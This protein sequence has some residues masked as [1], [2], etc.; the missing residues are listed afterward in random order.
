MAE[1]NQRQ[2]TGSHQAWRPTTLI[3]LSATLSLAREK[4][5]LI[6]QQQPKTK[7]TGK[8]K[9]ASQTRTSHT[10]YTHF[11][12]NQAS[13]SDHRHLTNTSE[14]RVLPAARL[15]EALQGQARALPLAPADPPLR[16]ERTSEEATLGDVTRQNK[17]KARRSKKDTG[18]S[19]EVVDE[20]A[21]LTLTTEEEAL[22]QQLRGTWAARSEVWRKASSPAWQRTQERMLPLLVLPVWELFEEFQT[23]RDKGNWGESTAAQYWAALRAA[24][25]PLRIV[26]PVEFKVQ[27][28]VLGWEAKEAD[29]RRQT[30]AA[31]PEQISRAA[32][33]LEPPLQIALE[34]AFYLGQRMGDTI[35][36][37]CRISSIFDT[38]TSTTFI[39]CCFIRGK[40]T[41]RR[42]PYT[43]H[44]PESHP[45]GQRLLALQEQRRKNAST[46]LFVEPPMRGNAL[47]TIRGALQAVDETLGLLSV[48]RGGLQKM[49]ID[50]ASIETLI[51][52]SRHTTQ[53]LLDRY[54]GWGKFNLIAARERLEPR[55][56]SAALPQ[57]PLGPS[58]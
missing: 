26:L 37:E 13:P 47:V 49:A 12:W 21:S 29:G 8:D 19:G 55:T 51:H 45:L 15:G 2:E 6:Q 39:T 50:G 46:F 22:L 36:L 7:T 24:A 17:H 48:R 23:R 16:R 18:S 44:V 58:T 34:L 32:Q 28:K 1:P 57:T 25:V 3:K 10:H 4:T 56:E 20:F 53:Q 43:L 27:G 11:A 40:T 33:L 41:R 5:N 35:Q 52:H 9:E 30:V 38:P 42:Q 54:L 14:P 31:T